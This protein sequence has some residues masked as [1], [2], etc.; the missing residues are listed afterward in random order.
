MIF[1]PIFAACLAVGLWRWYPNGSKPSVECD[2]AQTAANK[3]HFF[4]FLRANSAALQQFK[5]TIANKRAFL[6]A[7]IVSSTL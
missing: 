2:L 5:P 6:H 1:P 7:P 3:T 4:Y